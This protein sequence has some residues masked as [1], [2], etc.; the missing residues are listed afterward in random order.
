VGPSE[1]PRKNGLCAA[2]ETKNMTPTIAGWLALGVPM[3]LFGLV[4]LRR[5]RPVFL[6]YLAACLLGLG[7]LT[8]TGAAD[9]IGNHALGLA[10]GAATAPKTA[11]ASAPSK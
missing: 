1:W 5:Q 4:F 2:K 10:K 6:M 7:Y 11:P 3:L 8:A 9:D